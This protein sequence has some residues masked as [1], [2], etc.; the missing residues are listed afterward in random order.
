MLL[1]TNMRKQY[2]ED[3]YKTNCKDKKLIYIKYSKQPKKGTMIHFICPKHKDKGAQIKDWSHFRTYTYGCSYCSGRGQTTEEIQQKVQNPDVKIISPYLGNEKPIECECIKC[4]YRWITLP[5]VLITNGSGCP[6]CG[7]EKRKNIR[8]K[9]TQEF[10]FELQLV[11]PNIK[12]IGEYINTHTPIKC[13]CLIDGNI[14]YAYPANLLNRSAGCPRCNLSLHE[15]EMISILIDLKFN[16]I[17]QYTIHDCKY[18]KNLRFDA[19]D[20][21]RNI[22]FEYNG[23]Q[24]YSPIDFAGKGEEWAKNEFA[25]TQKRD[26]AKK[27]YC[28]KNNI[29]LIIIP[30]WEQKHMKDYIIS[31]LE[32]ANI[33]L[34]A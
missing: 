25:L 32:E 31:K 18:I 23:E 11:N 34:T 22:A 30:F 24:H 8:R 6:Q 10:I 9:S 2:T 15:S 21:G 14:W 29:L 33:S 27:E 7:L 3:D 16:V 1:K 5:K 13:Q 12:V 17:S 26:E 19:F 28:L 4:H 20:V